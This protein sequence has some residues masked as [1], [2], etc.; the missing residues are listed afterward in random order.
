MRSFED[1]KVVRFE[2]LRKN[3]R[4]GKTLLN[5]LEAGDFKVLAELELDERAD[6]EFMEPIL[7]AIKNEFNTY[8]AY[9]YYSESLQN[10]PALAKRI[11]MTE[12]ELI[13]DTPMGSNR[14]FIQENVVSNPEVITYMS[15]ELKR[16][17]TFVT[18]LYDLKDKEVSKGLARDGE[19]VTTLATNRMISNDRVFMSLAIREDV[20]AF[21]FAS[22]ELKNDS[23]FLKEQAFQSEEVIEYVSENAKDFGEEGLK[24]TK[25]VILQESTDKA[26]EDFIK[27]GESE[28]LDEAEMAKNE[29]HIKFLEKIKNDPAKQERMAKYF[30]SLPNA[31][32]N[33]E[34]RKKLEQYGKVQDVIN[35]RGENM[36]DRDV[37]D[38][39]KLTPDDITAATYDRRLPNVEAATAML[40]GN[41]TPE[42]T[43]SNEVIHEDGESPQK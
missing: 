23:S 16:D 28:E 9:K 18:G 5:S 26:L 3:E 38:E 40:K 32:I 27:K 6:L 35:E 20:T 25:E 21:K 22:E 36:E 11:I 2:D 14:Q 8:V 41:L 29:R 24:A 19:V 39:E 43:E 12:P 7:Y 4:Y 33:D 30:S 42:R 17:T 13:L 1:N 34:Y 15:P 10:N 37:A 31:N